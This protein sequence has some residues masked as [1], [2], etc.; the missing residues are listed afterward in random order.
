M[1]GNRSWHRPPWCL[2]EDCVFHSRHSLGVWFISDQPGYKWL[3]L[4]GVPLSGLQRLKLGAEAVPRADQLGRS[5]GAPG[6]GSRPAREG[7]KGWGHASS[8]SALASV[9]QR[10]VRAGD[11]G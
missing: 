4:K 6:R 9:P 7:E 11:S 1:P 8:G 10:L 5:P 2:S 3:T